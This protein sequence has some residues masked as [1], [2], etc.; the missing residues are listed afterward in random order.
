MR[1]FRTR[2]GR[3][4]AAF[5]SA[6]LGGRATILEAYSSRPPDPQNALDIFDGEWA[7]RLPPPFHTLRAGDALL[8]DDARLR[9]AITLLGS[10]QG[11]RVLELGPLEGGHTYMLDRAGAAD[12]L[13]IEANTRAY[14][15]CLIVKELL[16]LPSSRF[17]CGDFVSYLRSTTDRVDLVVASGV[18]YHMVHP[19][20]IIAR[21][22][23]ISDAVFIWTHYYDADVLGRSSA[24]AHRV[25]VGEDAI[26]EGF[27]HRLHRHEYLTALNHPGF[28]GGSR[29]FAH[30][31]TRDHI[32]G[33]LRHFGLTRIETAFEQTD[34][35]N[36]PAFCVLARR[37]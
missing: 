35:P 10:I 18:L 27:Q 2:A 32:V 15:K 5:T 13:A 29:P 33:A 21:I 36:G 17:V 28:C 14:M 12:V 16:R 34:H 6:A 37:R 4:A 26:Y 24:T 9:W 19:V 20:E 1:W 7:S 3:V 25:V 30:W 8:F 22:A 11:Q 23:S 31:L